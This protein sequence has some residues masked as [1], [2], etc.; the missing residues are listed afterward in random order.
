MTLLPFLVIAVAAAALAL[1][2]RRRARVSLA[3]GIGGLMAAFVAAAWIE[4][5]DVLII[6]DGAIVTSTYQRLFLVLGTAT[7]LLICLV[8]LATAWQRNVPAALLAAL[9]WT[10]LALAL[11]DPTIAVLA[12]A[13]G[14]LAGVLV[15][16]VAPI[17]ERGA[18]VS[19][20]ELRAVAVAGALGLLAVTVL[21]PS[22][23]SAVAG[24]AAVGL[25]FLAMVVAVA[26]RF[27]AIP[28]HT[29]A[30]RLSQ[31][32]PETALPLLLAWAP[33]GFAVVALAWTYDTLV[34]VAGSLG[35]DLGPERALVVVIGSLSLLVGT[36]AAWIQD[37]VEHVVG[38]SIAQDAGL[39]VLALAASQSGVWEPARTWIVIFVL[40]KTAFAA[41]ALA[42][43]AT[44]STRR[45]DD[46]T[47]WARRSPILGLA[48]AGIVLATLGW[49]GS[50]AWSA[51]QD[52]VRFAISDPFGT[53][54]FLGA[55][56][57]LVYYGRLLA[58]GLSA[59]S[60]SV[61]DRAALR[62]RWPRSMR[63]VAAGTGAGAERSDG[64]DATDRAEASDGAK[65]TQNETTEGPEATG[66]P[67]ATGE[68]TTSRSR[69]GDTLGR[70]RSAV[71]DLGETW[72]INRAPTATALVALLALIAVIASV[73]GFGIPQ[74]AAEGPPR[75]VSADDSSGGTQEAPSPTPAP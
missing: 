2:T 70:G 61:Q 3:I 9:A 65:A 14:G 54:V 44:Y 63:G 37:D 15:T 36:F 55:L 66:G 47:G 10:G 7:G 32:A 31:S 58:V 39:V 26:L 24:G 29:W 53:L 34:P 60:I 71:D 42:L 4:P 68:R 72:R 17:D 41:W 45:I 69:A 38:Y 40:A 23:G 13:G 56:T 50:V 11:P 67:K 5:G 25:A 51:R 59:P 22:A 21:D 20:R 52:I 16:L 8:G 74:A 46:L 18:Q 33:A 49:P 35:S 19:A 6:G 73:G 28:F 57:S 27:G 30:G 62:L 75:V 12:A 64:A 43:H 48:F 1:L